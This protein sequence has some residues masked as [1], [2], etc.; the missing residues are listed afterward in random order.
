VG[1]V[2]LGQRICR[3][4]A[5][6]VHVQQQLIED[7]LQQR[8][9]SSCK[10]APLAVQGQTSACGGAASGMALEGAAAAVSAPG[11]LGSRMLT[12]HA[13]RAGGHEATAA[14][15]EATAA[16]DA[17]RVVGH[18][19]TAATMTEEEAVMLLLPWKIGV[20]TE[21]LRGSDALPAGRSG[22][23]E[24]LVSSY[25]TGSAR[26][27]LGDEANARYP[28]VSARKG[29]PG[30]FEARLSKCKSRPVGAYAYGKNPAAP[31]AWRAEAVIAIEAGRPPPQY[32]EPRA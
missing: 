23:G 20:E 32:V 1:A 27:G 21:I 29:R 2:E 8:P 12:E 9:G 18:G 16:E 19:A 28:G 25:Y 6:L 15:K 10:G 13:C 31:C 7:A 26:L 17:I 11:S 22:G 4:P 5:I 3:E 24:V 30:Q 14:V